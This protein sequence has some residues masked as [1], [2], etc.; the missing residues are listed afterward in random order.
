[1]RP[2]DCLTAAEALVL[3]KPVVSTGR[4]TLK[5]ALSELIARK[6]ISVRVEKIRWTS[7]VILSPAREKA[8]NH[9]WDPVLQAAY[10]LTVEACGSEREVSVTQLAGTIRRRYPAETVKHSFK[11]LKVVPSLVSKGLAETRKEKALLFIP[12]TRLGLTARGQARLVDLE[13]QLR[14]AEEIPEMAKSN[15]SAAA[16]LLASLGGVAILV[17]TLKSKRAEIARLLQPEHADGG[18][19]DMLPI[20]MA[21]GGMHVADSSLD[22]AIDCFGAFD[23]A[24]GFDAGGGF[25]GGGGGDGG[26]S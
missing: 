9:H 23:G 25:D 20:F 3:Q 26:G 6:G 5:L 12:V 15:P 18:A 4:E 11:W 16:A 7:M 19:A 10:D 22:T 14:R 17:D 24:G 21:D 1:M 13:S 8:S 2:S